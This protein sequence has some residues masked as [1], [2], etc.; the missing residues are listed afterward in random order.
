MRSGKLPNNST[1]PDGAWNVSCNAVAKV[2]ASCWNC[3]RNP[4]PDNA[5]LDMVDIFA[6]EFET[7]WAA[8]LTPR[9]ED[10]LPSPSYPGHLAA[11]VELARIDLERRWASG[12]RP[13]PGEYFQRFP[14]LAEDAA[15]KAQLVFEDY[16]QRLL[17]GLSP[18]ADD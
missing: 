15:A 12:D 4:M 14:L 6:E 2:C 1:C 16:R 13:N 7:A 3:K 10:Y 8:G 5:L 17:A 9:I 18:Q 11:L